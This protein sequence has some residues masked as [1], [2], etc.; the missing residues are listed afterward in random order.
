[1]LK[2][3]FDQKCKLLRQKESRGENAE[4]KRA[5]VKDLHSRMQV[6]IHRIN[7]ISKKIEEI[8]DMELQ[9][10]L[11]ELIQGYAFPYLLRA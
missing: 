2:T 5:A 1:M 7:S 4:K 11:E 9:P 6:A 3:N 10:Q 8:R